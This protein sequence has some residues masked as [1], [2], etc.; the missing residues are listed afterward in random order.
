[1]SFEVNYPK[2][3]KNCIFSTNNSTQ[4]FRSYK[5]N[6]VKITFVHEFWVKCF[7]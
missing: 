3:V 2:F 5:F 7:W 4:L 1:M 6:W